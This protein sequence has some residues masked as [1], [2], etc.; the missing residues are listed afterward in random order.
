MRRVIGL[1]VVVVGVLSLAGRSLAQD[2]PETTV[3]RTSGRCSDTAG[4]ALG[5]GDTEVVVERVPSTNIGTPTVTSLGDNHISYNRLDRGPNGGSVRPRAFGREEPA[6]A[7]PLPGQR[8]GEIA[9]DA[10]SGAFPACPDQPAVGPPADVPDPA[11]SYAVRALED[12][13]LAQAGAYIAPG[14]AITG[15][16]AYLETRARPP[17]PIASQTRRS[18]P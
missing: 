6:T 11:E 15:M 16:F 10:A 9:V 8:A 3:A 7:P 2:S 13:P 4:D 17:T 12:I 14:R 1:V 5:C 18:G